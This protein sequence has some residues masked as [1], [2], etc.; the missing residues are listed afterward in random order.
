VGTAAAGGEFLQGQASAALAVDFFHV[1]TATLRRRY[2]LFA[3]ELKTRYVHILGVTANPDAV[4]ITQQAR[5][6]LLDLGERAAGFRYL[7]RNR[8]GQ[9][10]VAFD[11]VLA[12]AGISVVKIPPPQPQGERPRRALGCARCDGSGWTGP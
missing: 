10:T 7:V 12:E 11:T 5:D 9:F 6:L 3:L 4:W 1:E 2:V 8:A